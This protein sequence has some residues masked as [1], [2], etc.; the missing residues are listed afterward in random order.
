MRSRIFQTLLYKE[1]L[2]FRYNWGLLVM[3]G[4]V[5]ALAGL[6]SV[7]ARLGQLPGQQ[8]KKLRACR[9]FYTA[10]ASGEAW[11]RHLQENPP[12]LD[13]P[14][15]LQ[16]TGPFE[17]TQLTEF[18]GENQA[19]IPNRQDVLGIQ[20]MPTPRADGGVDWFYKFWVPRD[21]E[22]ESLPYRLWFLGESQR[23]LSPKPLRELY[24]ETTSSAFRRVGEEDRVPLFVTGLVIFSFY[25]LSFN[26][27]LTSTGEERDK[28][29][30]LALMLTPATAA[31][32]IGAKVIFYSAASL[33]VAM[34]VVAVYRPVLLLEPRIW[35]IVLFGSITYIAIAT[36]VLCLVRKQTTLNTVSMIYLIF[37]AL[38]MALASLFLPFLVLKFMLLENYA[39]RQ[40]QNAIASKP[41]ENWPIDFVAMLG[42]TLIWIFVAVRLF[43]QRGMRIAHASR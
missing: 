2:R 6:L 22:Q 30:L 32:I 21:S 12:R 41:P 7:S 1:A 28:K 13:L 14:G 17:F 34:A 19:V 40:L 39:F 31:E 10:G 42:I 4:G 16:P 20:L 18:V 8:G 3:V 36:V 33:L 9:I 35:L 5:V 24:S 37:T 26:L 27:Y 29:S 25:L 38:V 23:W 15:Y 43:R 11:A